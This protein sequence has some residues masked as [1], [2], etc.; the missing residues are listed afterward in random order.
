MND[1]SPIPVAL[2]RCKNYDPAA[3]QDCLK[4][5][6]APLG[7]MSAFVSPG[8]RV[9][10]KPN[11][12]SAKPPE[13]A[14]TTH[15]EIV[16]AVALEVMDA[17]GRV[18]LGDSPG[19]GSLAKVLERTGIGTV[20]R[21]LDIEIL[22]FN[23]S[24]LTKVTGG[25]TYRAVEMAAEVVD[26]E[27]IVNLPKLKT[28]GQMTLTMATKNMFGSVVGAAKIGWHLKTGQQLVFADLLLDICQTIAPDLNIMDGIIG[29]EGNGPGSGEPRSLGLLGASSDA[30]ALDQVFATLLG[31]SPA[32]HPIVF[33]ARERG[34]GAADP[35]RVSVKGLSLEEASVRDFILPDSRVRLDFSLPDF[36]SQPLKKSLTSFPALD[37]QR[38]TEC[39]VCEEIC[40]VKA[41]CLFNGGGGTVDRD[42]CITCYCCQEMCPEG[43]IR[44]VPGSL[45]KILRR[46]GMA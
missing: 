24:V 45:L 18:C 33:R 5:C 32:F 17:G 35:E 21:E 1:H 22:P 23:K 4:K 7:G 29:M 14:V 28:H 42:L 9:L 36:V 25:H 41:I 46:F 20:I 40:P 3:V 26:A 8:Q 11:L 2:Q 38:C 31:V 10:L 34:M 27:V 15:P 19:T 16:R 30:L 12:L 37:A 39:G 43:A 13:A 44:P 6:L